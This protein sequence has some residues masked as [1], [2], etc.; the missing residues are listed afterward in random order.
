VCR[1]RNSQAVNPG[2]R[3]SYADAQQL[4][5][6]LSTP[7]EQ[8]RLPTR[9]EL[10]TLRAAG[11]YNPSLN[12][13]VFPTAPAWSSDGAFWS[14]TPQSEGKRRGVWLVSAICTSDSWEETGPEHLNHVRLV[15]TE[16]GKHAAAQ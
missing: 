13:A 1:A 7:T 2:P 4:A 15:R 16:P 3:L 9:R 12:L 14:S 10:Q 11:C 6:Q 8:W 5:L